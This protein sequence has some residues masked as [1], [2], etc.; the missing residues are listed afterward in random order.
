MIELNN[1]RSQIS[2][3]RITSSYSKIYSEAW[4]VS[5]VKFL[6]VFAEFSALPFNLGGPLC[7]LHHP[8]VGLQQVQATQQ[9]YAK[10][11]QSNMQPPP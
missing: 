11:S 2:S 10:F 6:T 3:Q 7:G 4:R 8:Y 9:T 1:P 5:P